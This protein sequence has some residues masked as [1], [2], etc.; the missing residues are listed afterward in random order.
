MRTVKIMIM[1]KIVEKESMMIMGMMTMIMMN[2]C[3][4]E[5]AHKKYILMMAYDRN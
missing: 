5:I 4:K 2:C 3:K 1:I